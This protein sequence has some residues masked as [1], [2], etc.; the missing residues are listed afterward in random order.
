MND[1][2]GYHFFKRGKLLVPADFHSE[3]LMDSLVE[4]KNTLLDLKF[5][6]SPANHAHFFVV[7][8]TAW[9]HLQDE[10]ADEEVLLDALK[11]AVRH[12]RMVQQFDGTVLAL[13]KSIRFA[14]MGEDKFKR[15]KERALIV[16]SGRLGCTVDELVNE[17]AAKATRNR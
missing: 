13:P 17:I 5:P 2:S 3:D 1:L 4:E 15:F 8:H 10:Y 16:L 9:T 7:M 6:R 11:I 14:A 12:V